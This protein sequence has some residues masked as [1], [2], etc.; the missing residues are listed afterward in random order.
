MNNFSNF[1]VSHL[2][3]DKKVQ[4]ISDNFQDQREFNVHSVTSHPSLSPKRYHQ[5]L[6][7]SRL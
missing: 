3:H 6:S 7:L 1:F 4:D 2:G 5:H